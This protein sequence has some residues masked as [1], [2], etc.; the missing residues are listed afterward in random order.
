MVTQNMLHQLF[1]VPSPALALPLFTEG[2]LGLIFIR[3]YF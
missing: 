2:L 1:L 3:Y